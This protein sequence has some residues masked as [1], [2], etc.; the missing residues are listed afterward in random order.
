VAG[1]NHTPRAWKGVLMTRRDKIPLIQF[2]IITTGQSHICGWPLPI[3][4]TC[5]A[6][7]AVL[8][9]IVQNKYIFFIL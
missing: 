1:N 3:A 9:R 8:K 6:A 5:A 7:I 4:V 2:Q